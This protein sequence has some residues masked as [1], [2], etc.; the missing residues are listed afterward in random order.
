MLTVR[1]LEPGASV[2]FV[3]SFAAGLTLLEGICPG[4]A[5]ELHAA[6][7]VLGSAAVADASGMASISTLVPPALAGRTLH[8]QALAPGSCTESESPAQLLL[9]AVAL[10]RVRCSTAIDGP[11]ALPAAALIFASIKR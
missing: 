2:Y 10:L 11:S 1:G 8:L 5:L 6:Q 7:V 4:M 3:W 9:I